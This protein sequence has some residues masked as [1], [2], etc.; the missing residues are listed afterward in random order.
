MPD[1]RHIDLESL[2]QMQQLGSITLGEMDSVRLLNRIDTKYLT[3]ERTLVGILDDAAAAGYR[4]LVTEGSK[5]AEYDSIY[6]DTEGLQ[7]FL[8]HRNRRLTRQ[9]V[10]TR[11]YVASGQVFLEI[12]RKNNHGRTKKKRTGIPEGDFRDFRSNAEACGYLAGHSAFT[13]NVISPS[14]ETLFRRITLVNHEMTERITLDTSVCFNNLRTGR[15][16]S[17]LDGVVIELKQDGRAVSTMK[18]ILLDRRVKPVRVSKY[19][20][21]V[22]L[23]DPTARAGRFKLKVRKIEKQINKR[24]I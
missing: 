17:L 22:T 13:A 20:I 12:K 19:C 8:D 5:V 7:M 3:D 11:E 9:K 1:I 18:R 16:A 2:P 21:G 24:L 10:R 14:L 15:Q 23:T 4:A 6:F